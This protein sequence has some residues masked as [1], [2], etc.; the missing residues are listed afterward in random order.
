MK[1]IWNLVK[2]VLAVYGEQTLSERTG[3]SG[4]ALKRLVEGRE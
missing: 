1:A 3:L 2:A 4:D